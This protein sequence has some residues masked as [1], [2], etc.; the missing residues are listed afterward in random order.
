M[1]PFFKKKFVDE[2]REDQ[3]KEMLEFMGNISLGENCDQLLNAFGDFGHTHTNPIPVNGV[4]GEIKYLNRLRC[5]CGVGLMFHRLASIEVDGINGPV[6]IFETACLKGNYWDILYFHFYHPRRST[7]CPKGYSF[8]EFHPVFSRIPIAFGTDHYDDNFPFGLSKFIIM[9]FGEDKDQGKAF[10]S[11]YESFV[12]DKSKFNR[13]IEQ[14][15]KLDA[16]QKL[17]GEAEKPPKVEQAIEPK[18]EVYKDLME[19]KGKIDH[20]RP[21]GITY[22][23]GD[24]IGQKYEVYDILGMGGFG[25]VYLVYS[26]ETKEPYALKTFRDEFIEDKQVRDRFRKEAQVWI[27]LERHPYLVRAYFVDE[28]SGRL[29]IAMEYIASD[30]RGLTSLDDYLKRRPPDLAQTLRWAIQFCYGMEYAYLKGIRAHRD[31]KPA[32][33]LI[34]QDKAV[35]I[36]DFGLVGIVGGSKRISGVKL[37]NLKN[38][39]GVYQ[40]IEG[41]ALG[42]PPYMAPE[43]FL[44]A[45]ACDEK[46]DI[47][48]F[49]IVLYQMATGGNLPFLPNLPGNIPHEEIFKSWYLLHSQTP[50]PKLNSPLYPV[51]QGCLSKDKKKR[52]SSFGELRKE[53]ELL[54]KRTSGE[55]IKP[56]E[57]KEFGLWEWNAKGLSFDRLGR[58]NEA[59][60]CYDKALEID[61]TLP[62]LWNNKGL[63]L[64]HIGKYQDAIPFF[65]KALKINSEFGFAW[66]NKGISLEHLGHYDEAI[67]CYDK[68]IEINPLHI[69]AFY[70][71][72]NA[73]RA[74]GHLE[75][76]INCYDKALQIDPSYASGLNNKGL[77]LFQLGRLDEALSCINNVLEI[78][79][80]NV[81]AW[82]NKGNCFNEKG[83]FGEAIGCYDKAL[84]IV[85]DD[86]RILHKKGNSLF[87]LRRFEEAMKCYDMT[88][89]IDHEKA[90]VLYEKSLCFWEM[91]K[92]NDAL[93]TI[94]TAI[95]IDPS[96]P[97]FLFLKACMVDNLDKKQEAIDSYEQ[98]LKVIT[99]N[100]A[101]MARSQTLKIETLSKMTEEMKIA[102]QRIKFL[103]GK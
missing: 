88:L 4:R 77:T 9:Q 101:G 63:A 71:K 53:L 55:S 79:P 26:H 48:S 70:N 31:I 98:F 27:D 65:E 46:S 59:L 51:I 45:A 52:Y 66:N 13:P 37:G 38:D 72:G 89:K 32:N 22:K 16:I 14:S 47:Y 102:E 10:A 82:I 30:E 91:R 54:L 57:L 61:K 44:N 80:I 83:L 34:G 60:Q 3:K 97:S 87:R 41:I 58:F 56:P 29:F 23:K 50:V 69:E 12:K 15:G 11:K 99:S 39:E 100:I 103:R 84:E 43:Q 78:N 2:S 24:L 92:L 5:N 36:S 68:A 96:V 74:M 85:P 86:P 25:I 17:F 90:G 75:D 1:F 6:D 20:K 21:E 93:L 64:N 42:T 35:K 73:F 67:C 8:S 33:I 62:V 19:G 76:A 40:T 95:K 7:L 81:I 94:E 28:I 49:G 18:G